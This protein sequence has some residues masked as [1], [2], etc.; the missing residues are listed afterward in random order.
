MAG[1]LGVVG[2]PTVIKLPGPQVADAVKQ[3]VLS[4]DRRDEQPAAVVVATTRN[5][6]AEYPRIDK[7]LRLRLV[8]VA[9]QTRRK[10]VAAVVRRA[11]LAR[12]VG[13]G[14]AVE[15]S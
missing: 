13:P 8:L 10:K 14:K 6:V 9:H 7:L 1:L 11:A 2:P 5:S 3:V 4:P 15:I 12:L